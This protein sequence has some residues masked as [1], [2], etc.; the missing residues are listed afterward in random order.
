M[1]TRIAF[2][3]PVPNSPGKPMHAGCDDAPDICACLVFCRS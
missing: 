2:A 1:A 3:K